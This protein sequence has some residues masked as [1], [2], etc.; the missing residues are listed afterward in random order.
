MIRLLVSA[1]LTCVVF[2]APLQR[3]LLAS[4]E[5]SMNKRIRALAPGEEFVLLAHTH[6]VYL[7]G[8]GAVFTTR[9]NLFEG[10]G[11]NIFAVPVPE[12]VKNATH[13]KK[14]ERLP[15][16]RTAMTDML[17]D[18]AGVMDP[19]PPDEKIVLSVLLVNAPNEKGL[20]SQIVMQAQRRTLL[21]L[22]GVPAESPR[23]LTEIR[24]QEF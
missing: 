9:V 22:L 18:A 4:V 14:L 23:R 21:S 5:M 7:E 10:P 1:M 11:N 3:G 20:P 24:I 19:V 6:G 8:Y 12:S 16:L 2:A 15:L 13:Q 17:I